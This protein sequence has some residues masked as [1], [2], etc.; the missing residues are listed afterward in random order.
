LTVIFAIADRAI[1]AVFFIICEFYD[2]KQT[3]HIISEQ[4]SNFTYFS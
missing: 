1:K 2:N 4:K 3:Y